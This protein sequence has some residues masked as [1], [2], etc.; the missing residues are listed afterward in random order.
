MDETRPVVRARFAQVNLV[1]TDMDR[2][3]A[4]YRLLGVDLAEIA[5]EWADWAPHHQQTADLGEGISVEFDS[6]V[7]VVN[8][9]SAWE[10]G[11]TGAVIGF[12]VE[13]DEDVDAAV[14]AIADA[15]YR[16]IQPPH[17]AFFGARYALVEDP[18][19]IAVGITGPIDDARRSVPD[20]PA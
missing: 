15:G 11:R 7:S 19:G 12:L 3:L 6:S 10:P 5:E 17:D 2:S 4:F 1:I 13:R 16:V 14:A 20:L 9:A 8:W 18:D